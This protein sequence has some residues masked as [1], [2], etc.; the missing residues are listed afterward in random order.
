[1]SGS[2]TCHFCREEISATDPHTICVD[3]P[4]DG[5]TE[6]HFCAVCVDINDPPEVR[7]ARIQQLFIALVT[8]DDLDAPRIL[9]GSA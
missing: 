8:A 5:C 3:Y 6:T 9:P 7:S 4:L 1:M 2:F